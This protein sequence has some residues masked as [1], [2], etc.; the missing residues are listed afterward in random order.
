MDYKDILYHVQEHIA[1]ITLNRPESMN[2]Y[3]PLMMDELRDA[4]ASARDDEGVKVVV[5]T[6]AGRAF[7]A[8][9]DVKAMAR[10][11]AER[12]TGEVR[13]GG[14]SSAAVQSLPL[15]A[16]E[17]YK[18]LI[19]GVN[20]PAM[21]GG[22]DLASMCDIRIASDQARFAM[23]YIRV[24][25]V[26]AMGG[27]YLLPRIVGLS[28]ALELIWTGKAIDA[29]EAYRIGYVSRVVPQGE[30]ESALRGFAL[31]LAR[32]PSV[33]INLAK[34]VVLRSLEADM[35]ES[36]RL[37]AEASAITS[38]TEDAKEG[39]RAFAERREPRFQGR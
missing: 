38:K 5:L 31:T 35:E 32:G 15:L 22:M 14:L 34:R 27:S 7:C 13:G 19:A 1:T 8:G 18:P 33:A 39:P 16:K 26:P 30:F 4:L 21:G 6:G 9:G 3:T 36:F 17:L 2:A 28:N 11:R 37:V 29:Q 20:G 24:G 12:P 10:S 25:G 23:A